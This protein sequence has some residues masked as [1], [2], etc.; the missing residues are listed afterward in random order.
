MQSSIRDYYNEIYS[1]NLAKGT[2]ARYCI[3]Q[4]LDKNGWGNILRGLLGAFTFALVSR[5]VLIIDDP[6]VPAFFCC[7]S[8]LSWSMEDFFPKRRF[9]MPTSIIQ[10]DLTPD[11]QSDAGWMK[12]KTENITL[13]YTEPVVFYNESTSFIDAL[14]VNPH[15]RSVWEMCFSEPESKQKR[16][17]ELTA[18]LL[19]NPKRVFLKAI[20]KKRKRLK[21]ESLKQED[22]IS[23]QFRTFFDAGSYNLPYLEAFTK[24][25]KRVV[26]DLQKN[27]PRPYTIFITTDSVEALYYIRD[28]F[29]NYDIILGSRKV[30][31]TANSDPIQVMILKLIL[32]V[33]SRVVKLLGKRHLFQKKITSKEVFSYYKDPIIDWYMVGEGNAIISN[34]TSFAVLAAAR[35]GNFQYLYKIDYHNNIAEKVNNERYSF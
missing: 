2:A 7:P 5:R 27:H 17:G 26:D 31:H 30:V 19:G 18:Y 34:F 33:V 12:L 10:L 21:C 6:Y 16:V 1:E 35:R 28:Y 25:A 23:I 29:V 32:R 20:A 24:E 9:T 4:P 22:Q 14:H 11:R 3:Y 8:G 13:S 15:F